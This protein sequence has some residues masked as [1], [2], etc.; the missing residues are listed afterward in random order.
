MP[1]KYIPYIYFFDKNKK[2]INRKKLDIIKE[3]Y[4]INYERFNEPFTVKIDLETI[5]TKGKFWL[6]E[7]TIQMGEKYYYPH[8]CSLI[9]TET[10]FTGV[11]G[12]RHLIDYK[13]KN[14]TFEKLSIEFELSQLTICCDNKNILTSPKTIDEI[15]SENKDLHHFYL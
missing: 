9:E 12:V 8:F 13:I 3:N 2:F 4:K 14:Y 5:K 10:N 6:L 11:D 15:I 7:L 1:I